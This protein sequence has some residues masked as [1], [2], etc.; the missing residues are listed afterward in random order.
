MPDNPE[1]RYSIS[2]FLPAYNEEDNIEQAVGDSVEVLRQISDDWEVIVVND[3]SLDRTGEIADRLA[4]ENSSVKV[5]HHE[6][7]TRLGGALR[8]GFANATKDLVF[9]TDADNPIDMND[10]K[11][12]V[13]M[14]SDV[15]FITGY[16]LNRDEPLKRKIY[17]RCYNWIIRLLFGLRVRDV[18][19]SFKLVK[20]EIL[21]KVSLHSEGSFIDAELLIEARKYGYLVKE[22]G[23]RY[24]ARTKGVSTLASPSVIFKIF[25]ELW[26][27]YRNHYRN[28]NGDAEREKTDS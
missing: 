2:V 1:K 13:P 16:R 19:F 25:A 3:A 14:M 20:Q 8:T 6:K 17:S 23:I 15:D 10:L 5:I 22:V 27:Y 21:K 24:F 26:F 12:A 4:K 11:W 28:R 18:N 7:N 9:Y